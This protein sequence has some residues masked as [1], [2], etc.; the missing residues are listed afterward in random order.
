MKKR[1][2]ETKHNNP[3]DPFLNLTIENWLD[4]TNE[5]GYQFPF[6]QILLSEGHVVVHNSKHN[7]FEQG[8]DII[9]IN[10]EG[11]PCAYQLK[12][13]NITLKRWRE[14]VLP[15][16]EELISL[17]IE[18]PSIDK[19]KGHISYLVTNGEIE[20]TV[21]NNIDNLNYG[22]W[23]STPLNVITKGGLLKYFVDASLH[24]IPT[25][26]HEY[27]NLL[28]LFFTNGCE[29]IDTKKYSILIN[30]VL[31]IENTQKKPVQ[32]KRDIASALLYTGFI[33]SPFNKNL[34]HISIIQILSVL[35][36]YILQLVERFDLDEKY[37]N[38]SFD[39]I[40][41]KIDAAGTLLQ[42]EIENDGLKNIYA[43]IWDGEI[44]KYRHTLALTY[45]I[46]YKLSQALKD[47]KRWNNLDGDLVF[48][49]IDK[50]FV[51]WGESSL[52]LFIFTF[53]LCRRENHLNKT[54]F[55]ELALFL[56]FPMHI[57][58]QYN[59][60]KSEGILLSPY[61]SI[62]MSIKHNYNL[63][64]EPIID[65]FRCRSFFLKTLVSLATR[66]GYKEMLANLW[67]EITY[68]IFEEY[69]PDKENLWCYLSYSSQE[70]G[71]MHSEYPH[72]PQKWENLVEKASAVDK[73]LIPK[74]LITKSFFIPLFLTVIPQRVNANIINYIDDLITTTP[75]SK[76]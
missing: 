6:C 73:S 16:I 60:R 49:N 9:T 58:I 10:K 29:L 56:F 4:Q 23:K 8:K 71:E 19:S 15:E 13:G 51:P 43:D 57:I 3:T 26:L 64:D 47:D 34:N 36:T 17:Q 63:L 74:V 2:I 7:A 31:C 39:L 46:S 1:T 59:G 67:R 14:E 11:K 42:N 5:L 52:L 28:D 66:S 61:Y 37:W 69:V 54:K 32:R 70:F 40:W 27:K 44:G 65:G 55:D 45:F 68:I 53:L 25:Q 62:D 22:K 35:G 24:F 12:G 38:E 76:L 20:D 72:A 18:H 41:H 50:F 30:H 48:S 75:S 21:R 33:L